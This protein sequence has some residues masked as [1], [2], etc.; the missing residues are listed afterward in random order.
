MRR[1]LEL[2]REAHINFIRTSHYPSHP[3]F[4][5]LCDEMG[6]YVDCEVPFIHGRKNLSD[7]S[8]QEALYARARATVMRDKNRASIILWS[9]GNENHVN[10]LGL[11]AGRRVKELDPT[12]PIT[13]PTMGSHFRGNYQLYPEFVDLYSPHYPSAGTVRDYAEKLTRPIVVTEYAHQR[14]LS[15]GGAGVQEIWEA[16][17]QSPRVAG[18]AVWMFQDQGIL[19]RSD[20]PARVVNGDLMV[21]LDREHY[22]D[23]NGYYGVDGIVFSDRTPQTDFWQVRKVYSPVQVAAD[24]LRVTPGANRIT[25]KVENRHDFRSLAG[26][27]L[28]WVLRQN[29]GARQ[30]G[31]I[32]LAAPA[33]GTDTVVVN[34]E[35]PAA[36]GDDVHVLELQCVDANGHAL[37]ERALRLQPSVGEVKRATI[38]QESLPARW[39]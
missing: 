38:L 14:G 4:L 1:D 35:L 33:R 24:S 25:L 13:F 23:T 8:F 29:R 3:R 11:N 37:H 18:G 21:W 20:D 28:R 19:R 12:R 36:L 31:T 39:P 34:F 32:P 17:W 30:E 10:E 26:L 27:Q 2:M 16:I 9:L 22:Y 6:F 7:P 15:R 5:E